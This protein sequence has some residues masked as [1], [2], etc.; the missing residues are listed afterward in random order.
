MLDFTDI[1]WRA[2]RHPGIFLR[3][4]RRDETT[5]DATVLIRMD[6]GCAYPAHRHIGIEEVFILQGGY[7]DAIGTH[8]AGD[9]V[10]NQPGSTHYPVALD[11]ATAC[12][13]LAVARR[14]IKL[15][16]RNDKMGTEGI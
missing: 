16:S 14:G 3:V 11:G 2:T 9:Y 15:L 5:G 6:P 8:R 13:M 10:V 1:E 12:V 7:R 4:L